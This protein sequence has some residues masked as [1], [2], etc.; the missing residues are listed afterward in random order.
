MF[1]VVIPPK[2]SK[3]PLDRRLDKWFQWH[4][5]GTHSNSPFIPIP[6]NTVLI[7]LCCFVLPPPPKLSPGALIVDWRNNFIGTHSKFPL[8]SNICPLLCVGNSRE[9]IQRA[10]LSSS[11]GETTSRDTAQGPVQNYLC[12]PNPNTKRLVFVFYS[13]KVSQGPLY[14]RLDKQHPG[15]LFRDPFRIP[16][17]FHFQYMP[18]SAW[19]SIPWMCPMLLWIVA[20]HGGGWPTALVASEIITRCR[21]A[22]LRNEVGGQEPKDIMRGKCTA[23]VIKCA[24]AVRPRA[25]SG[26]WA[27]PTVLAC[28]QQQWMANPEPGRA[29]CSA[30]RFLGSAELCAFC[31]YTYTWFICWLHRTCMIW[32]KFATTEQDK[33]MVIEETWW[34]WFVQQ[35]CMYKTPLAM[36]PF[37]LWTS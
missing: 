11:I 26:K 2:V 13:P 10:S 16:Y 4:W 21:K 36:L 15:T 7:C 32:L 30:A 34:V 14:G 35:Y 24:A 6:V 22:S 23:A 33:Q 17:V 1:V 3:G 31:A 27:C 37:V 5:I 29:R 20:S 25:W 18:T 12:I 28:A 9:G 8:Y 19:F